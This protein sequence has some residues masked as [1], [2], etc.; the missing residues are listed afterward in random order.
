VDGIQAVVEVNP[1]NERVAR[2]WMAEFNTRAAQP[3][4]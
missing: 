1:K 4:V 2:A 3:Q